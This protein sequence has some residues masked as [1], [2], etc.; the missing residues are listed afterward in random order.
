MIA[1]FDD[2]LKKETVKFLKSSLDHL[3]K[4]VI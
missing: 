4:K 3:K 1:Y 2:D